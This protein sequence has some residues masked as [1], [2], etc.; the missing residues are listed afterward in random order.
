M[1]TLRRAQSRRGQNSA[2]SPPPYPS[3]DTFSVSFPFLI[4]ATS[5]CLCTALSE[6]L[7]Q[8]LAPSE[9]I[10]FVPSSKQHTPS[11][12]PSAH[13]HSSE[14]VAWDVISCQ[15]QSPQG[16]VA[17]ETVHQGPA[18]QEADAVPAQ[19]WKETCC[20]QMECACTRLAQPGMV[21]LG[22]GTPCDP[23]QS[24][25]PAHRALPTTPSHPLASGRG[26]QWQE[27]KQQQEG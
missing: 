2:S 23:Q 5:Q 13:T 25:S 10:H 4:Q 24:R 18:P 20:H 1:C 17:G 6:P 12:A 14:D 16:S 19:V 27:G 3:L 11:A 21:S 9:G 26:Q 15:L 7:L 22:K 8:R